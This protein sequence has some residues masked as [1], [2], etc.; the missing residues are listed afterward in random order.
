MSIDD[1]CMEIAKEVVA[2]QSKWREDEIATL[3]R[4][5]VLS[6]DLTQ[7]VMGDSYAVTYLP[8]RS[9]EALER[10]CDKMRD[11]LEFYL[12]HDIFERGSREQFL[13]LEALGVG[14]D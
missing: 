4:Q 9:R 14:H 3:L 8:Y 11:A 10:K 7:H 5:I 1:K 13:L 12:R 2:Q 6:G